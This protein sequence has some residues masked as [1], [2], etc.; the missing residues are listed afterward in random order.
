M[1]PGSEFA[2]GAAVYTTLVGSGGCPNQP[3]DADGVGAN[4]ARPTWPGP[5]LKP[6]SEPDIGTGD[7]YALGPVTTVDDHW[8]V[9][10]E[11]DPLPPE[12]ASAAMMLAVDVKVPSTFICE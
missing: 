12:P 7:G 4:D 8:R 10:E 6:S 1:I 2:V 3:G 11:T 5:T 9:D